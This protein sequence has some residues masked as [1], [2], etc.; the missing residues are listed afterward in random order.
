MKIGLERI[1]E[2]S[3]LDCNLRFTS[4]AHHITGERLAKNLNLMKSGT[5]SG[6]DKE[7]KFEAQRS[8][9]TWSKE[10]IIAIHRKGYKPPPV[11]RVFIPKPGKVEKRPIGVPTVRDRCLQRSVSEVLSAIYEQDF[12]KF[13]FGGRHNRSAH[14]ALGYLTQRISNRKVSWV[15][16]ADL[17]N[18]FGSLDHGWLEKFVSHRVGDPRILTLIKRWLKAGV[19]IDDKKESSEVGSPQGGSI[20]V[21]LS[22]IYLH[23]VLDLWFSKVVKPR[24]K[25]EAYLC[26]YLDDFVVCFQYKSD[27][28]RFE[29]SLKHR[30]SKFSLELEPS[31]TRLIP[32]GK[33]SARDANERGYKK[34]PVVSFLGFTLYG[35]RLPWGYWGVVLKPQS[36]RVSRF[37]NRLKEVMRWN[38]HLPLRE[39]AKA[40]NSRLRGFV[41]YFGLPM[42]SGIHR[43]IRNVCIRYWRKMLSSRSQSGRINWDRFSKILKF[44][45]IPYNKLPFTYDK[46]ISFS[47]SVN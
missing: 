11:R 25:G 5:G 32:F 36:S 45:P 13:S 44:H 18:F 17:K 22:N 4:L 34:P 6:I 39:Q 47:V 3:R 40:I 19:M 15:Y 9:N 14:H 26:R 2:K 8:F 12:L 24:L 30:L 27:A 38:R 43:A 42:T 1:A 37:L 28:T 10:M 21:V 41:N 16:E 20:S 7:S 35:T 33:F 23:Y 29:R 46:W 31:K